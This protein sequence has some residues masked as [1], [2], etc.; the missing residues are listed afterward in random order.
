[1]KQI[2][3]QQTLPGV[4]ADRNTIQSDVWHQDLTLHKETYYLIE[5]ES[6]GGKSSLC[7]YIYG[8]R[9]DYQGLITFDGQNIKQNTIKEWIHLRKTS[10]SLLFQELRLFPELTALENV[11]LKNKL[12]H[13]KKNSEIR[14]LFQ[15][16][17]IEEKLHEKVGKLSFGQQQ[18]VAFIRALCQPLDFILL[19]E[20]V[21]HLD[22][23]NNKRM[24]QLLLDEAQAQGCGVIVT[25]IGKPLELPYHE[26]LKL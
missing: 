25:S 26:T 2:N 15:Q 1:M 7:S 20:P 6:G 4:F 14:Q 12:T 19:D 8:Y 23:T 18:R 16:L 17:D 10:I 24:S 5:A 11:L 9:N 13:Y 21:S 22:D 3:L